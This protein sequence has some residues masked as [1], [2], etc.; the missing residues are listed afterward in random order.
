MVSTGTQQQ[1]Q[2][3]SSELQFYKEN[4][5]SITVYG[6]ESRLVRHCLRLATNRHRHDSSCLPVQHASQDAAHPPRPPSTTN[7]QGQ[8]PLACPPL[9]IASIRW[10]TDEPILPCPDSEG[11]HRPILRIVSKPYIS[12][13]SSRRFVKPCLKHMSTV[14][15]RDS[16]GRRT[17][18]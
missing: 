16:P 1:Q 9:Q 13:T 7:W 12:M 10:L 11:T 3:H 15:S 5:I 4:S 8:R 17:A 14:V 2:T 6:C 18:K